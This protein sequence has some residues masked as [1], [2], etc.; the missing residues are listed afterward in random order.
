[1]PRLFI[2]LVAGALV[3]WLA[4][5]LSAVLTSVSSDLN[6]FAA[7]D[8]DAATT[9]NCGTPSCGTGTILDY[10]FTA[11]AN[12]WAVVAARST[13]ANGDP[14]LCVYS[15]AAYS[16]LRAC[17]DVSS[18]NGVVEFVAMDFH[19][20]PGGTNYPRTQRVGSGEVCT[21]LDCGALLAPDAAPTVLTWFTGNVVRVFNVPVTAGTKYRADVVVTSGTSDFGLAAFRSNQVA[22][23]AAGRGSAVALADKRGAGQ[24]EGI[25]FEA[26]ASDT[27][28][29]VLWVNNAA[30]SANY[31]IEVRTATELVANSPASFGGTGQRDFFYAPTGARGWAV[32]ALRPQPTSDA[33]LRLFD[34]PDYLTLLSKSNAVIG[35]V[36]LVIANYAN[37]PED[38]GA[39]LMVSPGPLGSYLLDWHEHPIA[40]GSGG[41][42]ALDLGGRIG[43]GYTTQLTAGSQYR[44]QFDPNDGSTGDISLMLFGPRA[45]VP[46]FTYGTRADSIIGSDV[47]ATKPAGWNAGE[48]I[49]Q[50]NFTPTISG[51]YFL[52]AYQKTGASVSG[53]LRYYPTALVGA[54]AGPPPGTRLALAPPWPSPARG[55]SV[56]LRCDLAEAARADLDILDVRGR[57]VKKAY[58]GILPAGS[59]VLTWDGRAENG[60]PA[61]PGLYYA[62]LRSPLGS[63]SQVIVWLR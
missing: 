43:N 59:S 45:A 20:G 11:P 26:T 22:G 14:D 10:S 1:V 40:L 42:V 52:Y 56:R 51:Q 63:V 15:N 47:W 4:F 62:R 44:F 9:L 61:A 28:G 29:L 5:L 41:F 19:R 21:Q 34:S 30:T 27:I 38:T 55:E 50:F 2:L 33:D 25:Y 60:L 37:A 39:V 58:G 6:V 48:G 31:R 16:T 57:T 53:A 17:S 8:A 54:P 23:Y 7:S 35:V 12:S 24:G 18:V 36:D 3:I 49:E 46:N 13:S 32:L